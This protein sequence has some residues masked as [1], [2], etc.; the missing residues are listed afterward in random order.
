[1]KKII[2]LTESDLKKI[3]QKVL[4]EQSTAS[5]NPK[6]L[7]FG[8]RGEDVRNLQQKL[9]DAKV[10]VLRQGPTGYFGDLTQ[11][12]L[13]RLGG[14][15]PTSVTAGKK[16]PVIPGK[17]QPVI[18]SREKLTSKDPKDIN[19]YP[20]CVRFSR[21][22]NSASVMKTLQSYFGG[23]LGDWFINGE[24]FFEGYQFF[25]DGTY[26]S[27]GNKKK[28]T[29][30]CNKNNKIILDI[31]SKA[32]D[33]NTKK[34]GNYR[35]SPRIDAEV[36]HI[37]NR[38]LDDT[39]F[40]LYDPKD[41]L[42]YLF[43][44]GSK[45]I[46]HDSV[47]DGADVQKQTTDAFDFTHKDWCKVGGSVADPQICTHPNVKTKE[48]CDKLPKYMGAQFMPATKSCKVKENYGALASI[49]TRFLPKGI[50]TIKG[51]TYNK[52]YTGGSAGGNKNVWW[53][54]PIKLEGTITA[55]QNK[56]GMMQAIHG[57]P[58]IEERLKASKA[59]ESKLKSDV[60]SGKVPSQYLDDV[61]AILNAN[62]SYGCVGVP[63]KFIDNP[64]VAPVVKNNINSIKVFSLGQDTQ[65][66]LVKND[67]KQ[68]GIDQASVA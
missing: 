35:Y 10:L 12:A 19:S 20:S 4:N 60:S 52:G 41:N 49:A 7:K 28:G 17:N 26:T 53:L 46:A 25:N 55:A 42:I 39:P 13:N 22:Q 31:A 56:S 14:T 57:I 27:I 30:V 5:I 21:P 66:F 61:K 9:I 36:Q 1:M 16:Q 59:L 40:F 24:K 43:D 65:D 62:Q 32:I 23:N 29:Y 63:A 38:K 54:K 58:G 45:Y 15:P 50:Y 8:D 68:T 51:L 11:K 18:P 48:E 34:S 67:D 47:V 37:K 2:K 3:V 44:V 64:K 6:N 33:P